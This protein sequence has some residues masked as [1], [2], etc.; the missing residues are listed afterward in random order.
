[1]NLDELNL[2]HITVTLEMGVVNDIKLIKKVTIPEADVLCLLYKGKR[3]NL[4]FDLDYGVFLDEVDDMDKDEI[5]NIAKILK[6]L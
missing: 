5:N 2:A 6:N 4:K 3:V 1:M